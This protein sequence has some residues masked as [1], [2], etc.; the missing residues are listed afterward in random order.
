MEASDKEVLK[1]VLLDWINERHQALL[2]QVMMTWEE[3]LSRLK[4]DDALAEKL[5]GLVPAAPDLEPFGE[6]PADTDRDLGAALDLIESASGQ[7]EALKQLLSGLQPFT[8]RSAV[9]ILKQGIPSLYAH[10]GFESDQP[11]TG[12][13]VVP[14]R[15]LEEMIQGRIGLIDR[16][17]EAYSALLGP[18]S[19]F[20]ASGVRILPLRLRRKAVALLL[21]DSG[22]RQ[23]VAHPHHVRAL[24]HAAEAVLGILVGQKEDEAAPRPT[25][26]VPPSVATVKVPEPITDGGT[27]LDPKLRANAERN[28]RVLISD[29]E[30][31]SAA[32]LEQGRR[33]GN[34]YGAIR[35]D[36]ERSRTAFIER[37]GEDVEICHRIFYQ[38]VVQLLCDGDP[39]RLGPAPW[40]PA[41]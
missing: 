5:A 30:L 2:E 28:A 8:E 35:E 22:L 20:E 1:K 11:R 9:F 39:A 33:S 14:S 24:A 23:E 36:L 7:G 38:T 10:R 31:Y 21:V 41:P 18:L 3:G 32:K 13:T 12:S 26:E 40:K 16:P 29:I 27:P 37:F 17:G 4:P 15:D 34:L 25:V 19:R 6:L